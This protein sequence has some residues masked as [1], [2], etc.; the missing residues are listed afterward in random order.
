MYT[1]TI[2]LKF[3]P[4]GDS[5]MDTINTGKE[6][7]PRDP[8]TCDIPFYV[9]EFV[10][11]E[12]GNDCDSLNKLGKLIEELLENKMKLEEQVSCICL[13]FYFKIHDR[14][15]K[16]L[17]YNFPAIVSVHDGRTARPALCLHA[18]HSISV[19]LVCIESSACRLSPCDP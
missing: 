16:A 3:R 8:E 14:N 2:L 13:V 10:E 7:I 15:T 6:K 11:R 4:V 12:V 9:S 19:H 18:W 1:L 17:L 5:K